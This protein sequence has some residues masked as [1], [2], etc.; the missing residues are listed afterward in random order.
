MNYKI[1]KNR[2]YL[3][4]DKFSGMEFELDNLANK[5]NEIPVDYMSSAERKEL[6]R[7]LEE[8]GLI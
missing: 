6:I 2:L 8:A 7:K 5:I 3:N 4:F 1:I